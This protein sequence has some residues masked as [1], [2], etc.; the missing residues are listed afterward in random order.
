MR[1]MKKARMLGNYVEHLAK[2]KQLSVSDL[3]G[4]LNC[5]EK[6]VELFLKGRMYFSFNQ[7]SNLSKA[8]DV[9][10]GDLLAGDEKIYNDTVVHCLHKF[11]D[12]DNREM[13]L[14][15]IDDYVD[16]LNAVNNS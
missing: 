12:S 6:Y 15:L 4:I 10:V 9:S 7:V 5:E 16:I 2:E 1:G 11:S 8:L 3:G 13:I 14:D